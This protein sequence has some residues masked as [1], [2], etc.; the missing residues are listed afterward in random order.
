[1][2][3]AAEACKPS[4]GQ[5]EQLT[6][7]PHMISAAIA[8]GIT[9]EDFWSMTPGQLARHYDGVSQ[10]RRAAFIHD[11]SIAWHGAV[12]RRSKTLPS[13]SDIVARIENGGRRRRGAMDWQ[14]MRANL[15]ASIAQASR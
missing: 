8:S 6:D 4:D 5:R 14:E 15:R 12:F 1:M 2:G 10:A 3:S 9:E 13:L 11:I 7:W